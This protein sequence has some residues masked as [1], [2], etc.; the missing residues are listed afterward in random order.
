[1]KA[2]QKEFTRLFT[3][4]NAKKQAIEKKIEFWPRN[5]QI[6]RYNVLEEFK[7]FLTDEMIASL[8][9]KVNN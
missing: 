2:K 8:L 1:M 6:F 5:I 7:P 9:H 3:K 4:W